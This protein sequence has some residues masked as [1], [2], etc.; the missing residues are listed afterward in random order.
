[1]LKT[2]I[3]NFSS[4]LPSTPHTHLESKP[5]FPQFCLLHPLFPPRPSIRTRTWSLSLIFP[6]FCLLHP[7]FTTRPSIRTPMQLT[8]TGRAARACCCPCGCI[9]PW[10][11][12]HSAWSSHSCHIWD[13]NFFNRIS[14][15]NILCVNPHHYT[16]HNCT[17]I[18]VFSSLRD[19]YCLISFTTSRFSAFFPQM[20][21][22]WN[23]NTQL[24]KIPK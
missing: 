11:V 3:S 9:T 14:I 15:K 12:T 22:S 23:M 10:P 6:Q 4:V 17:Q 7:V 16:N 18:C 24:A 13:A 20:C 19:N 5:H 21:K 1:M 2:S 8:D